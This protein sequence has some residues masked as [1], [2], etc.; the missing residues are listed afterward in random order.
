MGAKLRAVYKCDKCKKVVEVTYAGGPTPVCCGEDM[1]LLEPKTGEPTEKHVPFIERVEGGVLV[2]VGRDA[3]HPMT[4]EHYIVYIEIEAD[5]EYM[6]KYLKP[7]DKPEAFFATSA[8]NI[9]AWEL[10]NLHDLWTYQ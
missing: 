2:K 6:R 5:G 4:E 3:P 10:C 7:G 8:K 9:V 1:R